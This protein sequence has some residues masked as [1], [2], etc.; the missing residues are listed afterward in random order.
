MQQYIFVDLENLAFLAQNQFPLKHRCTQFGIELRTYTSP[1]H[2]WADRATHL[3]RSMLKEATDVR[4]VVD[5]ARLTAKEKCRILLITDDE[6]FGATLAAEEPGVSRVAYDERLPPLWRGTVFGSTNSTVEE[7]FASHDVVRERRGRSASQSARDRSSRSASRDRSREPTSR[8]QEG[9]SVS[10]VSWTHVGSRR[11]GGAASDDGDQQ[12]KKASKSV[13][14]LVEKIN[15]MRHDME[16]LQAKNQ[17]LEQEVRIQVEQRMLADR[18]GGGKGGG[19]GSGKGLSYSVFP[20][21]LPPPPQPILLAMPPPRYPPLP[22]E[23][24]PSAPQSQPSVV[25]FSTPRHLGESQPPPH[26]PPPKPRP[27][28]WPRGV[29]PTAGKQVGRFVKYHAEKGFG[30][31]RFPG[32]AKDAFVHK[33]CIACVGEPTESLRN[34]DVEA[35]LVP[36]RKF[37]DQWRAEEVTGPAGRPIPML[38]PQTVAGQIADRHLGGFDSF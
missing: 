4:M 6:R 32:V 21:P 3:S 36:D 16:N 2:E 1:E 9:V 12:T 31:I 25:A 14:H 13:T 24:L 22:P 7:F 17:L 33:S 20:G 10:R 23:P 18:R 29:L 5:A 15:Q 34:W 19:K 30:F 27:R 26:P 38:N 37:G 35:R 8:S 28:Q 11:G